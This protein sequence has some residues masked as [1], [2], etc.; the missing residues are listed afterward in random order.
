MRQKMPG[1]DTVFLA[2]TEP[3]R[4]FMIGTYNCQDARNLRGQCLPKAGSIFQP[5][6][7]PCR[8]ADYEIVT[9]KTKPVKFYAG[10]PL[11]ADGHKIGTL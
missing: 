3:S 6:M 1:I 10:A 2:V 8:F 11:V 4:L 5:L 9:R 7:C